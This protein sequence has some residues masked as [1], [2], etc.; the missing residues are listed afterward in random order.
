MT[1]PEPER[2]GANTKKR[3]DEIKSEIAEIRKAVDAILRAFKSLE[4]ELGEAYMPAGTFLGHEF[5]I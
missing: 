4:D 5:E 2:S 3:V 1:E